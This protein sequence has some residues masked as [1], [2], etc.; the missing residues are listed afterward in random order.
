MIHHLNLLLFSLSLHHFFLF[1]W[2]F[3]PQTKAKRVRT[4]EITPIY[5]ATHLNFNEMLIPAHYTSLSYTQ[6]AGHSTL[7]VCM[8]TFILHHFASTQWTFVNFYQLTFLEAQSVCCRRCLPAPISLY[9]TFS[10]Y[11]VLLQFTHTHTPNEIGIL[12]VSNFSFQRKTLKSRSVTSSVES[13]L[14][15][16]FWGK[17]IIFMLRSLEKVSLFSRLLSRTR[18]STNNNSNEEVELRFTSLKNPSTVRDYIFEWWLLT[19]YK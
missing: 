15:A 11:L 19:E 13:E 14:I 2:K 4:L 16:Y 6:L 12:I 18:T 10:Q 8:C 9:L 7:C 1:S 3:F 17:K 5:S